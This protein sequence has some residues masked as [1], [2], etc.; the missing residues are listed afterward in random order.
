MHYY[1]VIKQEIKRWCFFLCNEISNALMDDCSSYVLFSFFSYSFYFL[2]LSL[3]HASLVS[4]LWFTFLFLLFFFLLSSLP[5]F[6]CQN[7]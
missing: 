4:Y 6:Y 2:C 3:S 5:L 1:A 7:T